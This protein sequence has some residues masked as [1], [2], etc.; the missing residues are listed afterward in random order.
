MTDDD[1][2]IQELRRLEALQGLCSANCR[3][4]NAE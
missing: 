3:T 4:G 1:A 2:D